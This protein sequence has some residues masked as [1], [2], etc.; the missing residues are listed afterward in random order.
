[1]EIRP[2]DLETPVGRLRQ[3]IGDRIQG[4]CKI[5][6]EGENCKCPLCDLDRIQTALNWYK[7]EVVAI[8]MNIVQKKDM[9]VLASVNVLSLDAGK[10]ITELLG[11][12]NA[13]I[14]ITSGATNEIVKES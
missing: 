4:G 2:N 10:R 7:D 8:S 11:H 13:L 14:P 1:M 3:F 6:S 9:A 12:N 5:L